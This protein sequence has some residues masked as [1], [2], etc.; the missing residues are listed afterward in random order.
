M[1]D[2]QKTV[3]GYKV[4]FVGEFSIFQAKEVFEQLRPILEEKQNITFDLAKV[5][6]IDTSVIQTFMF[7][8]R[9]L[10]QHDCTLNLINHSQAVL[11]LME[12]LGLV[13]WFNDPVFISPE[14]AENISQGGKK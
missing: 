6:S 2:I 1:L 9:A 3:D 4:F 12:R 14:A 7:I 13:N 11:D 8:K 10:K 5:V